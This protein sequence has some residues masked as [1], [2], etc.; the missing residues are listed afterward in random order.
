ML[1]L[2]TPND[3]SK[4]FACDEDWLIT[5]LHQKGFPPM[6]KDEEGTVY[7]KKSKKL[8]KYLDEIVGKEEWNG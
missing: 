7:F 8:V 4:F 1:I 5:R 2:G 6:Y 3:V